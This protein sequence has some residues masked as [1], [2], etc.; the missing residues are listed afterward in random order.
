VLILGRKLFSFRNRKLMHTQILAL[1]TPPALGPPT[2]SI[3]LLLWK[4]K[5]LHRTYAHQLDQEHISKVE[6]NL[7][8]K[9]GGLHGEMVG[10]MRAIQD[11]VIATKNYRKHILKEKL[12]NVKCRLKLMN[13]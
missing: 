12:E 10:F 1:I 4:Q 9:Q 13:I 2:Y 6:S 7:W 5:K 11:R 3:L 8:L